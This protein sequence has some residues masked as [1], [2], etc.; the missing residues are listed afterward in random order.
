M[1]LN[2]LEATPSTTPPP[3]S[4]KNCLPQNK[5]LVP[6]KAGDFCLK[7]EILRDTD[8]EKKERERRRWRGIGLRVLPDYSGAAGLSPESHHRAETCSVSTR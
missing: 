4:W 1:K 5:S 7:G 6:I 2:H 8:E 3:D